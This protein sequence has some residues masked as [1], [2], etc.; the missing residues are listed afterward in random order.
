MEAPKQATHFLHFQ[1]S[2]FL[3][4]GLPE[5]KSCPINSLNLKPILNS[6][7]Q[8]FIRY[9]VDMGVDIKLIATIYRMWMWI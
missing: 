9:P 3:Y 2:L 1:A 5:I 4:N 8:I 6:D 7:I